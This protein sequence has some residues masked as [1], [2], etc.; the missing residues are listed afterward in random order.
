MQY[1]RPYTFNEVLHILNASEHRSRPDRP[2]GFGVKGHAISLHT[3]ERENYFARPGALPVKDSTF[4]ISRRSMAEIVHEALNSPLGQ[5]RL[6]DLNKP[7]ISSV[8]IRTVILRQGKD[9]KNFDIFTVYRPKEVGSQYSFDWL[10]TTRA[11]GYIVQVFVLVV[12]VPG[13]SNAEIHI[14]T[15]F[16]EQYGRTVGNEIV[17]MR[18]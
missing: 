14:Q 15:A 5:R 9:G 16:P 12:K 13:S 3:A 1:N 8:G 7:E 18:K 4:L 2:S 11:D 17:G 10:S 6:E